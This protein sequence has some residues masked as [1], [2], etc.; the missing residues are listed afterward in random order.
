MISY[1]A[2]AEA[3]Y[4]VVTVVPVSQH[5]DSLQTIAHGVRIRSWKRLWVHMTHEVSM[6][7]AMQRSP[8]VIAPRSVMSRC[9]CT[10]IVV[11]LQGLPSP[12]HPLTAHSI[13]SG[14]ESGPVP[15]LQQPISFN[16][17]PNL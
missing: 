15:S 7:S 4:R 2:S 11:L 13:P 3:L 5:R 9:E 10:N 8:A 14:R 17:K 1:D 6:L 12:S 16:S